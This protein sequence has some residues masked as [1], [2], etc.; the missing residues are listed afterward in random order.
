[1]RID[2][3]FM[4]GKY[5]LRASFIDRVLGRFTER[6]INKP[7]ICALCLPIKKKMQIMHKKK[8]SNSA[9]KEKKKKKQIKQK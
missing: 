6:T 2:L 4:L 3:L 5:Q 9:Q 8:K 7:H 1:M